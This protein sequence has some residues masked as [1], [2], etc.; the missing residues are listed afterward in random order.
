[1]AAAQLLLSASDKYITSKPKLTYFDL[2]YKETNEDLKEC[3]EVPFDNFSTFGS[4]SRATIPT[5]K[6]K[7]VISGLT[8]RLTLPPIFNAFNNE[9][10]YPTP[11]SNVNAILYI[12]MPITQGLGDGTNII[13]TTSAPHYLQIG[14]S[15]TITNA[16]Y[17]LYNLNGSFI[18]SDVTTNTITVRSIIPGYVNT[19]TLTVIGAEP[20][21]V[22]P[23]YSTIDLFQWLGSYFA[24]S[25]LTYNSDLGI[26]YNRDTNKFNFS[27]SSYTN[28]LF[29]NALDASFWGFNYKEN[30]SYNF[31]SG[32]IIPQ[33]TL[34]QGGWVI[35]SAPP[36]ESSYIDSVANS[37]V[38]EVRLFIGNQLICKYSGEYIELLNDLVT[39]YENKVAL[40]IFE[41][42]YDNTQSTTN[43]QYYF[44]IKMGLDEIPIY[45]L[46]FQNVSIEVDFNNF[47]NLG[48]MNGGTGKFTDSKSYTKLS[49]G[50]IDTNAKAV[51]IYN[52]Y[53]IYYTYNY[54]LI[55]FNTINNSF[56]DLGYFYEFANFIV[57]KQYLYIQLLN[58]TLLRCYLPTLVNGD[59]SSIISNYL[60]FGSQPT[61]GMCC[62]YK[63]IYFCSFNPSNQILFIRYDTTLPFGLSSSYSSFNF[64]IFIDLNVTSVLKVITNGNSLIIIPNIPGKI[65]VH[66]LASDISA[67]WFTLNYSFA[68]QITDG[69]YIGENCYLIAD[70]NKIL[71]LESSGDTLFTTFTS[72]N[73]QNIYASGLYIYVSTPTS[74]IQIDNDFNSST[75]S[76]SVP[77][78]YPDVSIFISNPRYLFIFRNSIYPTTTIQRYDT[79]VQSSTLSSSI[80]VNYKTMNRSKVDQHLM[81]VIQPQHVSR[82]SFLD[83]KNPIK[84]IWFLGT[85]NNFTY[86]N[87]NTP[88]SLAIS[89]NDYL[90]TEDV[91]STAMLKYIGPYESHSS[92]HT[93]NFLQL[94]F[95]YYPESKIP[96]GTINF[97]R[98]NDQII[99]NVVSSIWATSYNMLVIKD[100]LAGLMFNFNS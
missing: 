36:I 62:D 45:S 19:G 90:L 14:T 7:D 31:Q 25:L 93:R 89:K 37:I 5:V 76:F 48:N 68:T 67:S 50:N 54:K 98:I 16:I 8:L 27:S 73:L 44:P 66:S 69:V 30:T 53:I 75:F 26:T 47:N 94:P 80:L 11:V 91:G 39:P 35:G 52:N 92:M 33:W 71:K 74:I 65:Y 12:Q 72:D 78:I 32:S 46:K 85:S 59:T 38:S 51:C 63:F 3:I 84:E 9:Y 34:V 24:N 20:S 83:L 2:K 28:I 86:S 40:Q 56:I 55:V 57:V 100:G 10:V 82:M 21:P 81:Y 87:I 77:Y 1:M 60:I 22:V 15:I 18:I 58:S 42:T 43:R 61:G 79:S 29:N 88:I 96:N 23:Y 49:S 4:T 6:G 64:S 13:F 95:E 70:G 97:S 99:S 17:A 41:G